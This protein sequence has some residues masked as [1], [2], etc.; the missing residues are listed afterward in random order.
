[1]MMMMMMMMVDGCY[2]LLQ[3]ESKMTIRAWMMMMMM[4]VEAKHLVYGLNYDDD[5]DDDGS[6]ESLFGDAA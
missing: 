5:D 2:Q 3:F 6:S 1:M 4:T